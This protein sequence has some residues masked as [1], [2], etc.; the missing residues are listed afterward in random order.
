VPSD[1]R[2]GSILELGESF[3]GLSRIREIVPSSPT[4]CIDIPL[5]VAVVWQSLGKNKADGRT[6]GRM[7]GW[8][9]GRKE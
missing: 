6:D 1:F 5:Q 9:E 2:S 7:D 3:L 4:Q 8:M